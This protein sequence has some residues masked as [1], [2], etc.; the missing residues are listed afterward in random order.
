MAVVDVDVRWAEEME[1]QTDPV[2]Q[3]LFHLPQ[4]QE[5]Q[6]R[7]PANTMSEKGRVGT[8]VMHTS[9]TAMTTSTASRLSSPRSSA[10]AAVGVSCI[11]R[12]SNRLCMDGSEDAHLCRV[13]LLKALEDLQHT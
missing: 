1:W 4:H 6:W 13:D 12:V 3:F 5:S 9:S 11:H 8:S 10:N 2:V 7:I